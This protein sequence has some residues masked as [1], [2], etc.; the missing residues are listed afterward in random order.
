ML[1]NLTFSLHNQYFSLSPAGIT[2]LQSVFVDPWWKSCTSTSNFGDLH[3]WAALTRWHFVSSEFFGL[4]HIGLL[5]EFRCTQ[6]GRAVLP[7][8]WIYKQGWAV[9]DVQR[10]FRKWMGFGRAELRKIPFPGVRI[11]VLVSRK[12]LKHFS[13][14]MMSRWRSSS[15]KAS[16]GWG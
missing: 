3:L 16:G 5:L 15:S 9:W 11:F 6:W 1:I 14:S 2:D 8:V 12:G 13:Q 7:W 4:V 10:W